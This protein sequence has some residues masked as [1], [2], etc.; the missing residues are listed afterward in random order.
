MQDFV[1]CHPRCK[2]RPNLKNNAHK[3]DLTNSYSAEWENLLRVTST[4]Y[5]WWNRLFCCPSFQPPKD[6]SRRKM[7][8]K[9]EI[10][11]PSRV[12]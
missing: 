5:I 10:L 9:T 12:V 6:E 4:H 7:M 3:T 8:Q 11:K 2:T 1:L